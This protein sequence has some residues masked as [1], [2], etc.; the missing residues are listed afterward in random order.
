IFFAAWTL[1][2]LDI[3]GVLGD[4]EQT[5]DRLGFAYGNARISALNILRA[6]I[7]LSVLLWFATLVE[8]FFE[9]RVIL[10]HSLTA[11]L[12]GLLIELLRLGLPAL[13]VL[14]ALPLVGINLT[15][16]T[17][18]G[19]AFAVGAG[20]GLQRAVANLVS[21]LMLLSGG[22]LRP[23]DVIAIRDIAG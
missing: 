4:I 21:G 22:S 16:L 11:F 6:A 13:A 8:R 18:F 5:L 7:V 10:P 15:T 14:I 19:G 1:A 12:Q 20:L 23:G 2:A 3:L 17:V 9:R